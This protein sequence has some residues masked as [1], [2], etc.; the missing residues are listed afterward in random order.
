MKN[1]CYKLFRNYCRL[2][3]AEVS[4]YTGIKK[5]RLIDIEHGEIT[6]DTEECCKIAK[7]YNISPD[8]LNGT[9]KDVFETIVCEPNDASF[10]NNDDERNAVIEKVS[11]LREDE[12]AIIMMYRMSEDKSEAFDK[13][14]FALSE[15]D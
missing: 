3:I 5:S 14:V 12:R 8:K 11:S 15:N 1:E 13:I 2:S 9:I 4:E 10:Y 7:L 6:P